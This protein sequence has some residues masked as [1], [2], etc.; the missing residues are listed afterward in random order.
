[1]TCARR[2]AQWRK[3]CSLLC[4]L[5]NSDKTLQ[6]AP[7]VAPGRVLRSQAPSS[8]ATVPTDR[9]AWLIT[10]REVNGRTFFY[11]QYYDAQGKK[12]ADYIGLTDDATVL[13]HAEQIREQ[14]AT[15]N[16]LLAVARLLSRGG[17]VRVDARTDAILA[18]L[19]NNELFRG[20]VCSS[21]LTRMG[22]CS[23]ISGH[24]P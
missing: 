5:E 9:N 4:N 18:A 17:Y 22:H 20:A 6:H 8:G 7:E 12:S 23:T 19:A 14:I 1:S 21:V 2:V 11:R 13:A 3:T 24:V 15:A 10:Q 16:A